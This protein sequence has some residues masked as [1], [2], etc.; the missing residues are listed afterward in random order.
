M[1][2]SVLAGSGPPGWPQG[3]HRSRPG[4]AVGL[5]T[6]QTAGM[7]ASLLCFQQ[8]PHP[9]WFFSCS[10]PISHLSLFSGSPCKSSS[11]HRPC[12]GLAVYLVWGWMRPICRQLSAGSAP[13][14]G[15]TFIS[16]ARA[17]GY[18]GGQGQ[19]GAGLQPGKVPWS[20]FVP[21]SSHQPWEVR[22]A[23]DSAAV[24]PCLLCPLAEPLIPQR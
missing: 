14:Q 10:S 19:L 4:Q 9:V 7:T 20:G 12:P 16:P 11:S 17:S 15:F 1:Q 6:P 23:E 21:S 13:E 18:W 24:P 5:S 22:P 2:R 8:P 3:S